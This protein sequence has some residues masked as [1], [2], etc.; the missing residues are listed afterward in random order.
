MSKKEWCHDMSHAYID[1]KNLRKRMVSD[2]ITSLFIYIETQIFFF[3]NFKII[4][5]FMF[6]ENLYQPPL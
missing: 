5:I 2:I 6:W 1:I 4:I 3:S